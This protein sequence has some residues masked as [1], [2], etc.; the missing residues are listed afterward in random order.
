MAEIVLATRIELDVRWKDPAV[1]PQETDEAPVVIDVAMAD[2]QRLDPGRVR[3]K[4]LS[5]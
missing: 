3:P 1:F 4:S 5:R 2:D